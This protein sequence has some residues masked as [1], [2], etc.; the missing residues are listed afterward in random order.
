MRGNFL[1]HGVHGAWAD[2]SCW[3]SVIETLQGEEYNVVA[4]Q[5]AE[6]GLAEGALEQLGEIGG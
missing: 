4:S 2:G 5:E 1:K 6:A 3:T